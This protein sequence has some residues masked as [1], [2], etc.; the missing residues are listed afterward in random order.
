[1]RNPLALASMAATLGALSLA[2]STPA[3]GRPREF[4]DSDDSF[5]WSSRKTK[6]KPL[7]SNDV[8]PVVD[9]RPESKRAK[10]RRL[11]RERPAP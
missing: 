8:G 3:T 1:M 7:T 10:R 5:V 11:A 4:Y 6:P 2:A 9:T